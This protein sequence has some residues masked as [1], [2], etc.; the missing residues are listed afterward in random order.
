MA[1]FAGL[2]AMM[3]LR[4]LGF[5]CRRIPLSQ[6]QRQLFPKADGGDGPL[7]RHRRN[8]SLQQAAAVLR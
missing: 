5:A 8:A 7:L 3:D 1:L 2:I 6:V 4:L